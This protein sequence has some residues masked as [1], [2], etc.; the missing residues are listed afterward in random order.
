MSCRHD[1]ARVGHL[2]RGL[3][4]VVFYWASIAV[5]SAEITQCATNRTVLAGPQC[6]VTLQDLTRE[7]QFSDPGAVA[8]VT[9]NP[10]AMTEL[11]LGTNL[12][13]FTVTDTNGQ[14]FDCTSFVV[15]VDRTAPVIDLCPTNRSLSAGTNCHVTLPDFSA[16]LV[17]TE[18]C[19]QVSVSQSPPPGTPVGLGQSVITFTVRDT[20]SNTSNCALLL[21]VTPPVDADPNLSISEFMARNT[22]TIK[23]DN[24]TYSDW[25]EIY[26][27]GCS[28]VNLDGWFLTDR[29]TQLT[30]WRFPATNLASGQFMIV[31]ASNKNRRIPGA[32]L[33]TNFKL[34][35]FGGYLALVQPD[36]TTIATQFYPTF[37]PQSRDVSYGLPSNR[38][39]EHLSGM[40]HAGHAQQPRRG[41]KT[42]PVIT[43]YLT[44]VVMAADTNCQA[45]CRT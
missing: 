18:A 43:W 39:D 12:V 35:E 36:R 38:Y 9:Q 24:G 27:A 45:L 41:S 5:A 44:N 1:R 29:R 17:A 30:R 13:S 3:L 2:F 16:E 40:A 20:A 33:H 31:W 19:S 42:P 32:P 34:D 22:V 21:T 8:S 4:S 14:T 10:S 23:D 11:G 6:T 25:I 15:V 7:V 28:P 26:N 37:P